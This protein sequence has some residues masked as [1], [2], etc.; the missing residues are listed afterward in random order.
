MNRILLVPV[1]ILEAQVLARA[2][3]LNRKDLIWMSKFL[4]LS[5]N[6]RELRRCVTIDFTP[7][8]SPCRGH[9]IGWRGGRPVRGAPSWYSVVFH[10]DPLSF[11]TISLGWLMLFFFF[12]I[13]FQRWNRWLSAA[14]LVGITWERM[15]LS[16]SQKSADVRPAGQHVCRTTALDITHDG[17]W[18]SFAGGQHVDSFLAP[19]A[20]CLNWET[21]NGFD[22]DFSISSAPGSINQFR[23]KIFRVHLKPGVYT[24]TGVLSCQYAKTAFIENVNLYW[25]YFFFFF[26]PSEEENIPPHCLLANCLYRRKM[27]KNHV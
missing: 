7:F 8:R 9:P 13:H 3:Q 12:C 22:A 6:L 15:V 19:C 18:P 1:S 23:S 17:W 5:S 26:S 2:F 16:S 20:L 11:S 21:A 24:F 14:I 10:F 4:S 27:K 25:V